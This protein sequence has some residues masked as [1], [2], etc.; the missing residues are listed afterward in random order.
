M[1]ATLEE[2]RKPY[3]A[4]FVDAGKTIRRDAEEEF[5]KGQK[6]DRIA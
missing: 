4:P 1:L 5:T 6:A 3:F 2:L